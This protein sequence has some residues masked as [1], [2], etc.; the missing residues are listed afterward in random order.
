M[1]FDITQKRALETAKIDLVEGSGAPMLDNDG[2]QLTVTVYGPGSKR[3]QQADADRNRKR[4]ARIEKNRGRLAAALD[5][6][7]ADELDFLVAITISF[8]GWSYPAPDG[9]TWAS[10]SDMF[11]AAYN[12]DTIGFI[13]DHVHK[14]ANDWSAFTKA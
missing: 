13:R 12:D 4:T 7:K 11:R 14:E 1:A 3:W 6:S 10:A 5:G 8:D 9:G 2:N